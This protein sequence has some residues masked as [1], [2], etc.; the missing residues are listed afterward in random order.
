MPPCFLRPLLRRVPLSPSQPIPFHSASYCTLTLTTTRR[1]HTPPPPPTRRFATPLSQA[2]GPERL[3]KYEE[4]IEAAVDMAR[5]PDE[6]V[7]APSYNQ[8]R[9]SGRRGQE[10]GSEGGAAG[11]TE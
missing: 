2:H 7:I 1:R 3:A 6:H 4:L 8:V 10:G 9:S 5:L 11:G